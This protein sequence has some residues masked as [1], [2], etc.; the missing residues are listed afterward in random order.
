MTKKHDDAKKLRDDL[1]KEREDLVAAMKDETPNSAAWLA[2]RDEVIR[3]SSEV[4]EQGNIMRAETDREMGEGTSYTGPLQD[5]TKTR[6]AELAAQEGLLGLNPISDW[7]QANINLFEDLDPNLSY[8]DQRT[9]WDRLWETDREGMLEKQRAEYGDITKKD[10]NGPTK[11]PFDINDDWFSNN[12]NWSWDG[13]QWVKS[14]TTSKE[15]ETPAGSVDMLAYRT[16]TNPYW[17]RYLGDDIRKG[18]MKFK[19][20]DTYQTSLGYLPGEIR[21]PKSWAKYLGMGGTKKDA[22]GNIIWDLP[23][24]L[25]SN[26]FQGLVPQGTWRTNPATYPG[27]QPGSSNRQPGWRFAATPTQMVNMPAWTPYNI[28]TTTAGDWKGLLGDWAA[29]T[30]NTTNLLGAA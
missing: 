15:L 23:A 24:G 18:L 11:D 10:D 4:R 5:A 7:Q 2:A 19:L 13:S 26:Q 30:L 28:D 1:V 22:Q 16:G 25:K 9:E 20:P 3:K 17:K 29:P 12:D 27:L 6:I 8:G 21:D 14:S